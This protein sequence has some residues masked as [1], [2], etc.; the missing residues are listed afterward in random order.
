MDRGETAYGFLSVHNP[1]LQLVGQRAQGAQHLGDRA[2]R[3]GD[4]HLRVRGPCPRRRAAGSAACSGRC[5]PP[6]TPAAAARCE[7]E[8]DVGQQRE[9]QPGVVGERRLLLGGL[10]ADPHARR[11]RPRRTPGGARRTSSTPACS[12]PRPARRPSPRGSRAGRG[13]TRRGR[14]RRPAS[15]W[16]G[17]GTPARRVRGQRDV[18]DP[19]ADQVVHPAG[20]ARG[21]RGGRGERPVAHHVPVAELLERE[22]HRDQPLALAR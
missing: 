15:R 1:A 16:S 4:R 12:R 2:G 19:R 13:R 18:R 22:Q 6:G 5:R 9:R 10:R 21:R 17:R 8:L 14:S 3:V 11:P 7:P 20:L